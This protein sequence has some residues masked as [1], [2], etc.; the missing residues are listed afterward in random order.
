MLGLARR[1]RRA[2]PI[3]VL[4]LIG[5]LTACNR[6]RH[7]SAPTVEAAMVT[8]NIVNHNVLDMTI[9]MVNRGT[10]AR[11]GQVTATTRGSFRVRLG[12][13]TGGEL[14]LYADPIGAL[15]GVTSDV[16]HLVDG[17]IVEWT[18]ESDLARSFLSVKG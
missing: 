16:V 11:I 18:L 8:V 14:Q 1:L 7:S 9:Y 12:Q 10:R 13:L 5:F 15:Q 6:L 2:A 3:S 4:L 17:Q